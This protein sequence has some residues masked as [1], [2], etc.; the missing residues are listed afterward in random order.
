MS[1]YAHIDSAYITVEQLRWARIHPDGE[2]SAAHPHSFWRDGAERTFVHAEI[3]ARSGKDAIVARV[4]A[5]LRDLLG[6][7]PS[8]LPWRTVCVLVR[9]TA[10]AVLKSTGSAFEDFVRDEYTTLVEVDDRIFSTSV[11]LTYTFVPVSIG[12]PQDAKKLDFDVGQVAGAAEVRVC[13]SWMS[14]ARVLK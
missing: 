11:D 1:R 5:G 13:A 7:S 14:W 10:Y 8:A 4:E 12:A 9:L 2:Q 3:D 6:A